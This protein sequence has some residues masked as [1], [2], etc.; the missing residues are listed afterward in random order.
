MLSEK[1]KLE[2]F[3]M[4]KRILKMIAIGVILGLVLLAIQIGFKIEQELFL[5][6]YWKI[7]IVFLLLVLVINIIYLMI[8]SKKIQKAL[9]L[10]NE[11]KIEQ[12]IDEMEL[13]LQK[14]KGENFRDLV[15]INLT[16]GYIKN[17]EYQK[18]L[19][20][21]NSIEEKQVKNE[22]LKL[23]YWINM[24]VSHFRLEN[25]DKFKEIYKAQKNLFEKYQD[26]ENYGEPIG[27]L[28]ILSAIIDDNLE[29]AQQL[30][31]VL[32][33]K[34]V[35]LHNQKDYEELEKIIEAKKAS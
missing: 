22:I 34:W 25:Y 5:S 16:A 30:L 21:L 1:K 10:L 26:N 35:N 24:A 13:I 15:K 7:S 31:D 12:Y 11:D 32:K 8:Y 3:K 28:Q 6:Y 18:S 14:I 17:R 9:I 33:N 27:Q 20:I 2:V 4:K 19:D 29:V 23:V